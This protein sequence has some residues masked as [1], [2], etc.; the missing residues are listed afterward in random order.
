MSDLLL[1]GKCKTLKPVSV[2]PALQGACWLLPWRGELSGLLWVCTRALCRSCQL[3]CNLLT[4]V[5]VLQ[6]A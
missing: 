1:L 6:K 2:L 4:T 3:L 5:K